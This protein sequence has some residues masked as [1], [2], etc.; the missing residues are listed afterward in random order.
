M[1]GIVSGVLVVCCLRLKR[2]LFFPRSLH[3]LF[4]GFHEIHK[5]IF[6]PALCL[7]LCSETLPEKLSKFV[8][9]YMAYLAVV[10]EE[11]HNK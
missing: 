8:M 7:F 2:Q 3:P 4:Q 5:T 11:G 9:E 1:R 10:V 6:F